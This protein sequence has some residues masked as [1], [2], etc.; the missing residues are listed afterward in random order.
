MN[1]A[2]YI[3]I[4]MGMFKEFKSNYNSYLTMIEKKASNSDHATKPAPTVK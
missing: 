3:E 2:V 4:N 1:L